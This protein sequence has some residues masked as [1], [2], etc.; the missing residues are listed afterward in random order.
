MIRSLP[1]GP[2]TVFLVAALG[3][4][5][6]GWAVPV[7]S[8]GSGPLRVIETRFYR[9][10]TD[11]E[12]APTQRVAEHMDK[13]YADYD[14]RF[15]A[16]RARDTGRLDAWVFERQEDYLVHLAELGFNARGTG[17]VFF[18]GPRGQ[19]LAAFVEGQPLE[20]VLR[21]LRHE[22]LH[23]FAAQRIG[24]DLPQWVN[25]GMAEFFGYAIETQNGLRSGLADPLAVA[26]VRDAVAGV[27][28]P[29]IPFAALVRMSNR[30]WNQRLA[31]GD[32]SVGVMYDQAWSV[33]HFLVY[34]EGGRYE[35]LLFDF[36][37]Q[38]SRG[39][40][41]GRASE[42]AFG[43]DVSAMEAAWRAYLEG[44]EPDPL[45]VACDQMTAVGAF[46]V[47]LRGKG[48]AVY[49]ADA[50]LAAVREHGLRATVAGDP[51]LPPRAADGEDA[52]WLDFPAGHRGRP[53]E[54]LI[55]RSRVSTRPPLV[56]LRGLD[57]RIVIEWTDA[58]PGYRV[59]IE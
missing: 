29:A 34:A 28:P 1:H 10:H 7:A 49:D 23:Q 18:R 52:W 20:L 24:D 31:S 42:S 50:L 27:G 19:G 30:D 56:M 12:P 54:L 32:A 8:A 17:G 58:A 46:L 51:R 53:A 26:R 21:V 44:L 5:V 9:I 36:L 59:V 57:T 4:A 13:I 2:L 33:V 6:S 37:R 11:L 16:F 45:L 15:S 47:A 48:V 25:E 39:V 55:R 43:R 41:A 35:R 22:G 14:R 40:E 38:I 3:A